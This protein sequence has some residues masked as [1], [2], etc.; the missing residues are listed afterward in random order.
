[1]RCRMGSALAHR[2]GSRFVVWDALDD[3]HGAGIDG[4]RTQDRPVELQG[5]LAGC[6]RRKPAYCYTYSSRFQQR[7]SLSNRRPLRD[8]TAC[9]IQLSNLRRESLQ[10]P[11]PAPQNTFAGTK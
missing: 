1:M 10:L 5:V 7:S 8:K 4:E 11:R 2:C 9:W 6:F 3:R